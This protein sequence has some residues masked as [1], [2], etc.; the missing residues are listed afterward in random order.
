MEE[1][2]GLTVKPDSMYALNGAALIAI[3]ELLYELPRRHN[4]L[5]GRIEDVLGSAR[6]LSAKTAGED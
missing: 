3:L 4:V 2:E 5:A 1:K 6:E